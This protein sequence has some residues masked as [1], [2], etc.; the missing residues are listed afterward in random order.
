MNGVKW[1]SMNTHMLAPATH[2]K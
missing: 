2:P 1:T